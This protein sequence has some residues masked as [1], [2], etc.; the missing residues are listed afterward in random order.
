MSSIE[1]CFS[2]CN[3]YELIFMYHMLFSIVFRYTFFGQR[4]QW[5]FFLKG[6][7]TT[8]MKTNDMSCS[9]HLVQNRYHSLT[10]LAWISGGPD[11]NKTELIIVILKEDLYRR[12]LIYCIADQS[13]YR[14]IT[15][16]NI[17]GVESRHKPALFV[18]K[19]SCD[20]S[21]VYCRMLHWN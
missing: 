17:M 19:Y 16:L 12:Y 6:L 5:Y 1:K 15:L 13:S 14:Y 20:S 3:F 7:N 9:I 18:G 4:F 10:G 21:S 8:L 2:Q 11:R